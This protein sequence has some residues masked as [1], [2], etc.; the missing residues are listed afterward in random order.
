MKNTLIMLSLLFTLSCTTV[1]KA[2]KAYDII[3]YK[4]IIY[5]NKATL[6]LAEGYLLASKVIIRSN[7]GNKEFAPLTNEPDAY[8]Q[9][10]FDAVTATGR[11]KGIKGSWITLGK[12]NGPGYPSQIKGLY[13]DGKMRKVVVF[14]QQN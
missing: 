10:R 2:Q 1:V 9:L 8:D 6:Q 5:G 13:W 4:T 11:F 7:F 12:L 3:I 14:K